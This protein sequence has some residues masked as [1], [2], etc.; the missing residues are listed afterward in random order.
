MSVYVLQDK[1]TSSIYNQNKTSYQGRS[2]SRCHV[3]LLGHVRGHMI[4]SIP[5]TIMV[6]NGQ[7]SISSPSDRLMF[8]LQMYPVVLVNVVATYVRT[9]SVFLTL[10]KHANNVL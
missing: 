9:H 1:D 7:L 4:T 8:C 5:V 6:T 10:K 3:Y 2:L